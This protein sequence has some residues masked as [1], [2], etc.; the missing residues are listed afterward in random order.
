MPQPLST[1]SR[2][3]ASQRRRHC[4]EKPE[5]R[6][7]EEPLLAATGDSPRKPWRPSTAKSEW[8]NELKKKTGGEQNS[9]GLQAFK[10]HDLCPNY[11][12]KPLDGSGRIARWSDWSFLDNL[13]FAWDRCGCGQNGAQTPGSD[14]VGLGRQKA[15]GRCKIPHVMRF[16]ARLLEVKPQKH[17]LPQPKTA[18][19]ELLTPAP[20]QAQ[21]SAPGYSSS[22]FCSKML[23]EALQLHYVY[24]GKHHRVDGLL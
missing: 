24:R 11:S 13:N 17:D 14:S 1:S 16:G 20:V 10:G 6:N 3:R 8:M 5:Q 4:I 9:E 15:L 18:S 19:P 7:E 23:K 21:P 2:T 12:G 22:R